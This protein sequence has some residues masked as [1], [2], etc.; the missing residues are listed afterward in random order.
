MEHNLIM[1]GFKFQLLNQYGAR[2]KI[3]Q[4]LLETVPIALLFIRDLSPVV[5]LVEF[6]L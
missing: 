4:L 2:Y 3:Q 5:R 1:S 6:R